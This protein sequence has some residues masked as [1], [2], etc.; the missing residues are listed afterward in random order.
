M[1]ETRRYSVTGMSCGHCESAIRSEV[2]QLPG[3][4]GVEVSAQSGELAITLSEDPVLRDDAVI[5]AVDEAGYDA[6]RQP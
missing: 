3:V 2:E 5:A 6:L 4:L 1:T